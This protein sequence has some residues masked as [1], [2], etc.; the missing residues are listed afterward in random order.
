MR[1]CTRSSYVI[2]FSLIRS[3]SFSPSLSL[4]LSLPFL[5]TRT[6]VCMPLNGHKFVC[7][8]VN[9]VLWL[10]SIIFITLR[11]SPLPALTLMAARIQFC[12]Y[13]CNSLFNVPNRLA[14][15]FERTRVRESCTSQPAAATCA[16]SN[17]TW[18]GRPI[19]AMYAIQVSF[20]YTLCIISYSTQWRRDKV[21]RVRT[22]RGNYIYVYLYVCRMHVCMYIYI[23]LFISLCLYVRVCN[24]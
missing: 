11:S 19:D 10:V 8:F 6:S 22:T 23:Y 2:T 3:L 13:I 12:S 14:P 21:I 5:S 1:A 16:N 9:Y 18:Y 20:L 24:S 15:L 7:I 17:L 4:V